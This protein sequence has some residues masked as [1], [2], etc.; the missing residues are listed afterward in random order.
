MRALTVRVQGGQ[1]TIDE[2]PQEPEGT[3][4]S[5]DLDGDEL[6]PEEVA[7]LDAACTEAEEDEKAGRLV[8]ASEVMAN[9]RGLGR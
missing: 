1:Y 4:F 7:E 5:L 9:L 3:V 2:K 6:S 8:P